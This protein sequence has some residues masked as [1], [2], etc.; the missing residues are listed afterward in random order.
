MSVETAP[1]KKL[2]PIE[3]DDRRLAVENTIGTMCIEGLDPDETTLQ[4]LAR[5]AD[6][7]IEFSEAKRLLRQ[8]SSTIL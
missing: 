6:G 3:L 8:Y 1:V 5:Y 7:Q 4:I 2:S